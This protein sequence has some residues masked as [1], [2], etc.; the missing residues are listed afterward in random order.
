[1]RRLLGVVIAAVGV[2]C[3]SGRA[4]AQ[5]VNVQSQI[6]E[7]P[8][9][10]SGQVDA[11]A[12]WR[13]GNTDLLILSGAVT[14]RYK[15]KDHLVFAVVK[16]EYGRVG[17]DPSTTFL[18][19]TF[20]HVRYRLRLSGRVTAEAFVQHEFDGFRRLQLR[21]LAGAGARVTLVDE[22]DF[23]VIVGVAYMFER[24][25]LDEKMGAMDAGENYNNHRASTYALLGAKVNDKVTF[26]ETVYFQPRLDDPGDARLLSETSLLVKLSDKFTFK[27]AFVVAH[28][29]D[30]PDL[31]EK[32]DTVLQS[33][34]SYKF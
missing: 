9:G 1:M 3:A 15:H 14:T 12:D 10:V 19:H 13:T 20:E 18:K 34:V 32:T 27:T 29:S 25:E 22:P 2:L 31:L 23:N 33:N 11:G 28:D 26:G 16:G 24:E 5:I 6:G 7:V 17:Q 30:P 21:A 4:E 8:E